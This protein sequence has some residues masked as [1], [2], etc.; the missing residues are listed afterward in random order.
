MIAKQDVKKASLASNF[1]WA[2]IGNVVYA[3][4][5]WGMLMVLAKLGSTE[6]VGRF[7]L[8]LA[9]TAPVITFLKFDLRAIQATDIQGQY[10]F[11]DYLSL[12]II[13]CILALFAIACIGHFG[14]Y[15][16][17]AQIV[18]LIIAVAKI[19]EAIC[20]IFHGLLQRHERMDL[21]AISYLI[22]GPLSVISLAAGLL[23]GGLQWGAL[24]MLLSWALVFLLYDMRVGMKMLRLTQKH[25]EHIK[26]IKGKKKGKKKRWIQLAKQTLPMGIGTLLLS[27]DDNIPR[28]FIEHQLGEIRLGIFA[29][30][31]YI[32]VAGT[33]VVR[34]L[35]YSS[36]PR[37]AEAY[38]N[39]G[40]TGF[41][42]LLAKITSVGFLIGL[43][44]WI[45][46]A[47]IGEDLLSIFYT[48]RYSEWANVFTWLMAGSMMHYIAMF[49]SSGIVVI[50]YFRS[51]MT[52]EFI[53]LLTI[54]T[55][56]FCLIPGYGILG[57]AWAVGLGTSLHA[58][59]AFGIIAYVCLS[60]KKKWLQKNGHKMKSGY[61]MDACSR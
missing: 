44:G 42:P 15:I 33:T 22:K 3:G 48:P 46:S 11:R 35:T 60:E 25:D 58:F 39:P 21:I 19:V 27:L 51:S 32:Q 13:N 18:I 26:K 54:V 57:A 34:A 38:A 7:A 30:M 59:G 53:V 6:I 61:I 5:Q 4:C 8:G 29:A 36:A 31:A 28:L 55:G 23:F 16:F 1:S 49:L 45:T 37:L 40:H 2:F 12:R 52:L 10:S 9:I 41:L 20:D 50:R 14:N 24:C 43:A 47:L 56:C 17:D